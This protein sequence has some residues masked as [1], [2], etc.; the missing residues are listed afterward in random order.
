MVVDGGGC[1][2][3]RRAPAHGCGWWRIQPP[4]TSSGVTAGDEL[5]AW[6]GY[7]RRRTQPPAMSSDAARHVDSRGRGYQRRAWRGAWRQRTLPPATSLVWGVVA[8]DTAADNDL[9]REAWTTEDAAA[10]DDL[11]HGA[12]RVGLPMMTPQCSAPDT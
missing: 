5:P 9:R 10:G 1:N 2:L 6:H 3:R 8:K 4:V 11:R 12:W 7:G